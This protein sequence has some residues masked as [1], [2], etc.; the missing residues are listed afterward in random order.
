METKT[1]LIVDV[2]SESSA[3][4]AEALLNAQGDL[5]FLVHV[6]PIAGGHR[7]YLRRYKQSPPT[8]AEAA[9]GNATNLDNVTALSIVRANRGKPVR[10][11]VSLLSAAG[12][13]R[14]RQ[15]VC[16]QLD[17]TCAEDGKEEKALDHVKRYCYSTWE[18]L[19]IVDELRI[20]CK[21]KRSRAWARRVL[22]K[23][24]EDEARA[25]TVPADKS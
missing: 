7:A 22:E 21:I 6:L 18:P 3:A 12:I 2:P 14:G 25:A 9:K 17:A 15:W 10:E 8:K 19:D 23:M 5:Y 13:K 1:I 16:E 11:I 24:R 20:A 4:Q